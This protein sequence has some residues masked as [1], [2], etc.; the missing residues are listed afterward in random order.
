MR[1]DTANR[2]LGAWPA[3]GQSASAPAAPRIVGVTDAR[4]RRNPRSGSRAAVSLLWLGVLVMMPLVLVAGLIAL[5]GL[6]GLSLGMRVGRRT[7]RGSQAALA[8]VL[9]LESSTADVSLSRAA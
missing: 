9:H 3:S 2:T 7:S 4:P 6:V 1:I 5:T 8:P